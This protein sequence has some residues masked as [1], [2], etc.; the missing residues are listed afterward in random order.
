[1]RVLPAPRRGSRGVPLAPSAPPDGGPAG[2][3]LLPGGAGDSR[4]RARGDREALRPLAP[5][6]HHPE[7]TIPRRLLR[8]RARGPAAPRPRGG[9]G[10]A[11]SNASTAPRSV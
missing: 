6:D 8:A 9:A 2:D 7:P 5:D 10:R 4:P 11:A 3:G 1:R